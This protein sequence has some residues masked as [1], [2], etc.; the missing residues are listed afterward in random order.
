M[1]KPRKRIGEIA[2]RSENAPALVEFYRDVIGLEPYASLGSAT[3]L[4][5]DEDFEGHPQIL[6]IFQV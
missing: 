5:V 3:F 2:L 1:L 6:A 4:K